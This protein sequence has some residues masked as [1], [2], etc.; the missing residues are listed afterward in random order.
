MTY[1]SSLQRSEGRLTNHYR[2]GP[3]GLNR[4]TTN[5][6]TADLVLWLDAD[7]SNVTK[8][9]D[10]KVSQWSDKSGLGHHFTQA[11]PQAV[12]NE[13]GQN[14][15]PSITM[16]SNAVLTSTW[17]QA[18]PNTIYF[19]MKNTWVSGK[20]IMYLD[21]VSGNA[22]FWMNSAYSSP[23]IQYSDSAT[24]E[25]RNVNLQ[26]G[27]CEIVVLD[28]ASSSAKIQV[29]KST[30]TTATP[31]S[32]AGINNP[33]FGAI[34]S[35]GSNAE[36]SEVLIYSVTHNTTQR[37]AVMEYLKNKYNI[38]DLSNNPISTT[39]FSWYD[40]SDTDWMVKDG[41]NY[42]SLWKDKSGFV[43]H[44]T[45][46]TASKQPLYGSNGITFDGVDDILETVSFSQAQPISLFMV[47]E[48][49]TWES[50][51]YILIGKDG[52][53]NNIRIAQRPSSAQVAAYSSGADWADPIEVGTGAFKIVSIIFNGVSNSLIQVNKGTPVTS[54][55]WS[56]AGINTGLYLGGGSGLSFANIRIKES[57]IYTEAVSP[58]DRGLIQDYLI[59]KYSI[60]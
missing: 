34:S 19:V 16:N 53:A 33:Y 48:Q 17:S 9:G 31:S 57:L 54:G 11:S 28:T 15:L 7:D 23:E 58:T 5:L 14:G 42:V 50:G 40:T 26:N 6:D 59:N 51:Q 43:K 2:T 8:D 52:E 56:T 10:N 12:W 44:L 60:S 46:A 24:A 3:A 47:L 13:S 25:A 29:S 55:A 36:F 35:L 37:N 45:Q 32:M 4:K 27:S 22:K 1:R 41:S 39:P 18:L 30:Q 20:I 21:G 38:W 49:V